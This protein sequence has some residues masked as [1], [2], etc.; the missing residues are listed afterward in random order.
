METWPLQITVSGESGNMHFIMHEN[1]KVMDHQ[2]AMNPNQLRP[3]MR[4]T[5]HG[6]Q[7]TDGQPQAGPDRNN[8]Y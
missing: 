6:I 5:L 3:G 4:I 1:S 8:Q 2:H 7:K